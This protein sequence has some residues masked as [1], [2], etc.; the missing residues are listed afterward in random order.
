LKNEL[1]KQPTIFIVDDDEDDLYFIKTSILNNIENSTV[2]CFING[3]QLID[4]LHQADRSSPTLIIMDLNMPIYNGKE[5]LVYLKK[6]NLVNQT[7]VIIFSTSNN[8][9]EKKICIQHGASAYYSKPA[10]LNVYD[11]IVLDLKKRYLN[12][13]AVS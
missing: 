2:K 10:S 4:Y 7:P 6:N 8:P 12:G 1:Y 13:V 11:E 9:N 3:K 5:T